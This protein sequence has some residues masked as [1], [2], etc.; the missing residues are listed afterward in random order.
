MLNLSPRVIQSS[1]HALIKLGVINIFKLQVMYIISSV[2]NQEQNLNS[3]S[4]GLTNH[5]NTH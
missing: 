5:E 3:W 1:L 4:F 2:V